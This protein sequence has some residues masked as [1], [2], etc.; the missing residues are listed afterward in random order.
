MGGK[1]LDHK[2]AESKLVGYGLANPRGAT[3][4][5]LKFFIGMK[6]FVFL[7]IESANSGQDSFL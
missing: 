1:L 7:C 2:A 3:A 4:K 6:G 5:H